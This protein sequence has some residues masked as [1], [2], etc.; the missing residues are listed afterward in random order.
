LNAVGHVRLTLTDPLTVAE[1]LASVDRQ[2]ADGAW[3]YGVLLDARATFRTPHPMA[4]RSFV[5]GVRE[6]LAAH[7]PRGPIAIVA[8][9]SRAITGAKMNVLFGRQMRSIDVFRDIDD[10]Q[11]WLDEWMAQGPETPSAD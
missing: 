8:Q 11:Q 9:A 6:R 10:A 5:F 2:L 7:G 3:P 1:L 4:M